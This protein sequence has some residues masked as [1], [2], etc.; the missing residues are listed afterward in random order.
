LS[1]CDF[2]AAS[3]NQPESATYTLTAGAHIIV[4][5]DF[6]ADAA[7]AQIQFTIAH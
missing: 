3:A 2:S 5:N 7:G 1:N 6:G 4:L